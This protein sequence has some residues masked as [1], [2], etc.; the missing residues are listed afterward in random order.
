MSCIPFGSCAVNYFPCT[1]SCPRAP[2]KARTR[3]CAFTKEDCTSWPPIYFGRRRMKLNFVACLHCRHTHLLV[4]YH[5]KLSRSIF[6][7]FVR[8][9]TCMVSKKSKEIEGYKIGESSA[10]RITD[11]LRLFKL[12]YSASVGDS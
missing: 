1:V 4:G 12:K 9:L 7:F 2:M 6:D 10:E 11:V 5:Q 8:A 3:V